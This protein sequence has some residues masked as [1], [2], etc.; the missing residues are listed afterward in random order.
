MDN[1]STHKQFLQK[2]GSWSEKEVE[3]WITDKLMTSEDQ[4]KFH[5]YCQ[6]IKYK[7]GSKKYQSA[8]LRFVR[9]HSLRDLAL[10]KALN[11][12]GINVV[13][14]PA[15]HPEFQPIERFWALLKRYFE[16]TDRD[17]K[18]ED[19]MAEAINR[20]PQNY[21]AACIQ[22]ALRRC[23]KEH[24]KMVEE[25]CAAPAAA[26][27]VIYENEPPVDGGDSSD[28]DGIFSHF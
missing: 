5:Q 3:C 10:V 2:V 22:S 18:F 27:V 8:L 6:D 12:V 20:I 13:Y 21:A 1:A 23:W 17:K 14:T 19:R 28:D 26:P 15:Y 11:D 7:P 16:E 25:A 4:A 9:E 24:E